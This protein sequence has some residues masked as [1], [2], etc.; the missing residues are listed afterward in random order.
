MTE[1]KLK[2]NS[3]EA[4]NL[5]KIAQNDHLELNFQE[6]PEFQNRKSFYNDDC[7]YMIIYRKIR[8]KVFNFVH[9]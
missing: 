9:E 1:L 5:I 7:L 6:R 2:L 8:F 3:I 4:V